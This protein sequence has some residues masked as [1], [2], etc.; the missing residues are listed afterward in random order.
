MALDRYSADTIAF[1]Y[2]G[3]EF[4]I[5]PTAFSIGSFEIKW[6]GICIALGLFL[7]M[8]YCFKRTKQ[9]GLD[10]DKLSD[11]VFAGVIGAVIGARAYYV[12]FHADYYK[13]IS[14]VFAIRDGGL[15]VYGGLIGALILGIGMCVIRKI[16]IR[17]AV[18]LASMGF[19]IGQA[20]GRW[21]NF[22]NQEA[23]GT[24]TTLPWG[25][26]GG[27]IQSYIRANK[28]AFAAQG[29]EM[30]SLT[31]VH[32]C[33][34][35]ES[36]WC[37][38]GFLIAHFLHKKRKFDGEMICFYCMW[39]G[40]GRIFIE[41]LRTDSLYA[42]DVRVSQALSAIIAIGGLVVMVIG[43]INAR[44]KGVHLYRDSEE[45]KNLLAEAEQRDKEYEEARKNKK[46]KHLSSDQHIVD[47]DIEEE[48]K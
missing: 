18:D 41:S 42:G 38:A 39:Y 20:M 25:M 15:A 22:F 31:P 9:F 13:N 34:L 11:A 1:P 2:L 5:S 47:V 32:P 29:F 3:F 4:K 30:D 10:G 16:H 37:L 35:Y 17:S 6:Y 8:H 19:F 28:A 33:F 7:A 40:M 23:F 44:K 21:G 43:E 14:E 45:A 46:E 26:S 12:A 48:N 24:N 27:R 36:L